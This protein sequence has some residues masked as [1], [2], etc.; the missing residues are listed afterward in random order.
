MQLKSKRLAVYRYTC[1]LCGKRR[2]T[3]S[4]A[5]SLERKCWADGCDPRYRPPE[6][7]TRLF[8]PSSLVETPTT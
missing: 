6:N 8:T 5:R 1:V 7:A 2:L 4:Y 3:R